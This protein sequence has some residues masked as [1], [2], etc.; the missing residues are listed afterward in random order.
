MRKIWIFLF[1]ILFIVLP[2]PS[3]SIAA[4]ITSIQSGPWSSQSTWGG[5]VPGDGDDVIIADGHIVG[6]DQDIG[7]AAGGGIRTVQVGQNDRSTSQLR[8][9][10]STSPKGM[11]ITFADG[12][13]T[14]GI[15]FFG[16]L[17]LQGTSDH[18]LLITPR[19]ED[20]SAYLFIRKN[21][22]STQVQLISKN[23]VFRYLGN[24]LQ[25]AIDARNIKSGDQFVFSGNQLDRSGFLQLAG[26]DGSQKAI[27]VSGNTATRHKGSFV[28]FQGA[29][30]LTIDQNQVT[31][32]FFPAGAPG[33]AIIDSIKGDQVGSGITIENNTLISEI[34]ADNHLCTEGPPQRF[35]IWL[36]GFSNSVI[37]KNRIFA[38]GTPESCVNYPGFFGF[39]EGIHLFGASGDASNVLI[40]QNIISNS[41]HGIG[42][43]TGPADTGIRVIRNTLFDNRNEHIFI[44]TGSQITIAN[45]LL[46][47]FVHS[48]QAGIL[49]YHTDHVQILNN[50][51]DGLDPNGQT[52]QNAAGIAIGDKKDA[53]PQNPPVIY[54]STNV[55]IVNNILTHWEKGVQNRDSNNSY[56]TVDHNLFF[57]DQ[58]PYHDLGASPSGR[59][60]ASRPGDLFQDPLYLNRA[61]HVYHLQA[62]S[63]AIDRG[64]T[65]FP[66]NDFDGETRPQGSGVDIGA[67]EFTNLVADLAVEM[68]VS[69]G[70]VGMP[71]IYT[72]TLTNQGPGTASDVTLT[73]RVPSGVDIPSFVVSQGSC[74][75]SNPATCHLGNL[76][77]GEK[78][79]ITLAVTPVSAEEV[80]N[81]VEVTAATSDPNP[82]NNSATATGKVAV[83]GGGGTPSP[84]TTP[85]T[86]SNG[87][88]GGGCTLAEGGDR[89]HSL[90]FILGYFLVLFCC[91]KKA[92]G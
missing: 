10:G 28:Q 90:S 12:L 6:I 36:E 87:G 26:G 51:V 69:P 40:D 86:D 24:E 11:T 56:L 31:L 53:G 17:D 23:N 88:G 65:P 32:S 64:G 20:G 25:P 16:K 3:L 21:P 91:K 34:N 41:I 52:V 85:S 61:S 76:L 44:D 8:F 47:G 55:T 2:L 30:N 38:R 33:Q 79:V 18:P 80:S 72:V 78:A 74:S 73:D 83:V 49:L 84:G 75:G 19:S 29:K 68:T 46:Y 43:A 7:T 1:I 62:G 92:G 81:T 37:R 4:T 22:N 50:T 39:S 15:D 48:G 5:I 57:G 14:S 82:A 63:P 35:G 77:F 58:I 9:D 59:L 67:D 45:N 71:F 89:D 27:V 60:P 66:P 70:A 54:T 13:G 42:V